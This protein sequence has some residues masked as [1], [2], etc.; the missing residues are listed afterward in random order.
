MHRTGCLALGFALACSSAAAEEPLTGMAS[1]YSAVP[2]YSDLTAARR[3]LPLGTQVRVTR[4]DTG[5]QVVVRIND[6]GPFVKG[7][8]IDVSRQAAELLGMIDAGVTRVTLEVVAAQAAQEA[9]TAPPSCE[10]CEHVGV[11]LTPSNQD[12]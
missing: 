1:F 11:L 12:P 10:P 8:I 9:A 2:A 3:H 7:R 4:I 6:R 5:K